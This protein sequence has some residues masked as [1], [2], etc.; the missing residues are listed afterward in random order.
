MKSSTN[1][2]GGINP[3]TQA[4]KVLS[5]SSHPN[6]RVKA[7]SFLF[8]CPSHSSL[9]DLKSKAEVHRLISPLTGVSYLI[10]AERGRFVVLPRLCLPFHNLQSMPV[11]LPSFFLEDS[12]GITLHIK[13]RRRLVIWKRCLLVIDIDI[14]IFSL[15]R[16]EKRGIARG[17]ITDR[18]GAKRH[19]RCKDS[20]AAGIRLLCSR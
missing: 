6:R 4:Q 12:D 10:F 8:R 3:P 1:F 16:G 20:A 11:S 17:R 7:S 9:Q 2:G 19:V 5:L 13:Y 18:M 14:E 15:R